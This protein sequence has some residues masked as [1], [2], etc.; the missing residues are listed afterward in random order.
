MLD[1]SLS[2]LVC[3][4]PFAG[5][6]Y[7]YVRC[8][9]GPFVG[10][11]AASTEMMMYMF[12]QIRTMQKIG[13]AFNNGALN[14]TQSS[15][16]PLWVFIAYIAVLLPHTFG[17]VH[18]WYTMIS[19]TFISLVLLLI[20]LISS[21]TVDNCAV[22]LPGNE[23]HDISGTNTFME[24]LPLPMWFYMGIC[25]LPLSAARIKN[26]KEVLPKAMIGGI[27]FVFVVFS[28]FTI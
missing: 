15:M 2:E 19:V 5:G 14:T 26:E 6:A 24:I 7:G 10:F 20:Y 18:F 25:T 3:V 4:V 13:Q 9:L 12:Y 22:W 8:S 16:E 28:F 21:S 1:T 27:V 23:F 11:L 17:G